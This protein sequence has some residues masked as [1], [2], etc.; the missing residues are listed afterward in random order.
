MEEKELLEGLAEADENAFVQLYKSHYMGLLLYAERI[1]NQEYSIAQEATADAFIELWKG[2]RQFG[3]MAQLIGYLR[4]IVH[5]KCI[6]KYRQLR[7]QQALANELLYLSENQQEEIFSREISLEAELL[8][9]IRL[10]VEKLPAHIK[11]VFDLACIQGRRNA[12]IAKILNIK[13]ATVRRRKTEALHYLRQTLKGM[14]WSTMIVWIVFELLHHKDLSR[15]I[16]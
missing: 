12:E 7:R 6:D 3:N 1:T 11:E 2:A 9:I 8:K 10:E 4:V 15:F 5:H 13:D 16:N 14:G